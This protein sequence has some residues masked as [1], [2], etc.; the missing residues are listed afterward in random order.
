MNDAATPVAMRCV[1]EWNPDEK[2]V[3][4]TNPAER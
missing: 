2:T 4:C 3:T 1:N